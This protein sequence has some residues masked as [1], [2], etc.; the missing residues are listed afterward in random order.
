MSDENVTVPVRPAIGQPI[1]RD[2]DGFKV[3][4]TNSPA[5]IAED[6]R[7]PLDPRT[8]IELMADQ[9]DPA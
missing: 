4:F 8:T 2:R 7:A 3:L 9:E 1:P 5:D 6:Y